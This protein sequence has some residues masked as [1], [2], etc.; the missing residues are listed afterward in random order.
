MAAMT[1][2]S[3]RRLN[4]LAERAKQLDD[5]IQKAAKMQKKIVE[6]I[7]RLGN[8][9]KVMRQRTTRVPRPRKR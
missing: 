5:M 8:A 1:D 2:D 4:R 9:D 7:Q 6:A 3:V